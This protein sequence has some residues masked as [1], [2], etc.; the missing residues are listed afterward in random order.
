MADTSPAVV[1]PPA[2]GVATPLFRPFLQ[3]VLNN[4]ILPLKVLTWAGVVAIVVFGF[5]RFATCG[6]S[7]FAGRRTP[8]LATTVHKPEP[9]ANNQP[10]APN[11]EATDKPRPGNKAKS[12]A[13]APANPPPTAVQPPA[14]PSVANKSAA[15]ALLDPN[16]AF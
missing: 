13:N 10:S 7:N 8:I 3:A 6:N 14:A 15:D 11:K 16:A 12:Q 9:A 2:P 5:G 1:N 4:T